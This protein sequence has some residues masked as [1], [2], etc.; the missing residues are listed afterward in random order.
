MFSFILVSSIPLL[1][2]Q[3]K[4]EFLDFQKKDLPLSLNTE[5]VLNPF[6]EKDDTQEFPCLSNT[7]AIETISAFFDGLKIFAKK[8]EM[9]FSSF[10]GFIDSIDFEKFSPE[11]V[12]T[13]FSVLGKTQQTLCDFPKGCHLANKARSFVSEIATT[14]FLRLSESNQVAFLT[15]S[16]QAPSKA[17]ALLTPKASRDLSSC[18]KKDEAVFK[19]AIPKIRMD[20]LAEVFPKVDEGEQLEILVQILRRYDDSEEARKVFKKILPTDQ[21]NMIELLALDCYRSKRFS[22]AEVLFSHLDESLKNSALRFLEA[23]G[24]SYRQPLPGRLGSKQVY[25]VMLGDAEVYFFM[26]LE[27]YDLARGIVGRVK[28]DLILS[29]AKAEF[30]LPT[31]EIASIATEYRHPMGYDEILEPIDVDP[32]GTYLIDEYTNN[33]KK[34]IENR[35]HLRMNCISREMNLVVSQDAMRFHRDQLPLQYDFLNRAGASY[36]KCYMAQDLTLMD[37]DMPKRSFSGTLMRDGDKGDIFFILLFPGEV[38]AN[39]TLDPPE[40]PSDGSPPVY[41]GATTLP[42]HSPYAPVDFD[43]KYTSGSGKGKRISNVVRGVVLDKDLQEI[44]S[45]AVSLPINRAKVFYDDEGHKTSKYANGVNIYPIS[46]ALYSDL[47]VKNFV[48]KENDLHVEKLHFPQAISAQRILEFADYMP[49]NFSEYEGSLYRVIKRTDGFTR[50]N[51]LFCSE[52]KEDS[53]VVL[54]NRSSIPETHEYTQISEDSTAYRLPWIQMYFLPP[55]YTMIVPSK[56][57]KNFC[58]TPVEEMFF[59]NPQKDADSLDVELLPSDIYS[60]V[61][62]LIFNKKD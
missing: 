54:I 2:Y 47:D 11:E 7:Q 42:Y 16:K 5:I 59:R 33:I 37:W 57:F 56:C 22:L 45:R 48:R 61:D 10:S 36:P 24:F 25:T 38:T 29:I 18:I 53:I 60:A 49:I 51:D 8:N 13:L 44:R 23:K 35:F 43:G 41:P 31:I 19:E 26:D 21:K 62:V 9:H 50:F 14:I 15:N 39:F 32:L 1:P 17:L 4:A 46:N 3:E 52:L 12:N 30:P 28:D 34:N 20:L 6:Y 58:M 27:K 55:N 40:Y